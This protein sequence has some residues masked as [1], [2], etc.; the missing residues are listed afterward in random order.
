MNT[1]TCLA[2]IVGLTNRECDCL[3]TIPTGEN[4]SKSGF[5]IDDIFETSNAL[6]L[7]DSLSCDDEIWT[8]L[9][10]ARQ[11]AIEDFITDL[12]GQL[13]LSQ[14]KAV[15]DWAGVWGD[16]DKATK[17]NPNTSTMLGVKIEAL[18]KS[19]MGL[20]VRLNSVGL[21]IDVQSDYN[22]LLY[23]SADFTTP[24]KT[25]GIS[26]KAGIP[27][28]ATIN[29]VVLLPMWNTTTGMKI[30][31]Y[32]VYEPAGANPYSTQF[33][34]N[35]G[36]KP[37]W[38]KYLDPAG[39]TGFTSMTD[40]TGAKKNSRSM[41]GLIA[42]IQ[43]TCGAEWI[44]HNWDYTQDPWARTMAKTIAYRGH[45]KVLEYILNS[46]AVNKYTTLMEPEWIYGKLKHYA[47]EV[48]GRMNYLSTE[49]PAQAANCWSCYP[50]MSMG[51]ILV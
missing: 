29:E 49:L 24:L 28:M 33:W 16:P 5:Y 11:S 15:T 3:G 25:F 40:V 14:M 37:G 46:G 35:C 4:N 39:I 22:I 34:C 12:Q 36:G 1:Q 18:D 45:M 6:K 21:L 32:L 26:S 23:S 51:A 9:A 44:C 19:P 7:Q 17:L 13:S 10:N 27:S 48:E 50:T 31:Y 42:S 41:H 38:S 47:K 8:V 20:T 30:S 2:N 43:V